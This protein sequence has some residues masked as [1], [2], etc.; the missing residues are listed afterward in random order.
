VRRVEIPSSCEECLEILEASTSPGLYRESFTL[1]WTRLDWRTALCWAIA[2]RVVT[3]PYRRFVTAYRP[4]L[5]DSRIKENSQ[6][7]TPPPPCVRNSSR[8]PAHTELS[9]GQ[10]CK[11]VHSMCSDVYVARKLVSVF[12]RIF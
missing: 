5:H 4:H 1:F 2:W 9:G 7:W 10:M 8:I 11:G 6:N 12:K 3:V